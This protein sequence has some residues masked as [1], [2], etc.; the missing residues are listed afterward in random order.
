MTGRQQVVAGSSAGLVIII[1]AA[2][3]A[4]H[5]QQF[6][7]HREIFSANPGLSVCRRWWRSFYA[8]CFGNAPAPRAPLSVCVRLGDRRRLL[9]GIQ[10]TP[11]G[12]GI[13]SMSRPCFFVVARRHCRGQPRHLAAQRGGGRTFC[14]E[15]GV[16]PRGIPRNWPR[17]RGSK[18][19]ACFPSCCWSSPAFFVYIWR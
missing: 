8:A 17:C 19:S 3:W 4:P 18:T 1:V 10:R 12:I 9:L 7:F 5:I 13:F 6:R 15:Y 16:L 11:L 14:L 2:F